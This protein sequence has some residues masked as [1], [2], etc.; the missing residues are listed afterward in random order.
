MN[1]MDLLE[2]Y[3]HWRCNNGSFD[4]LR[5]R[6]SEYTSLYGG[7]FESVVLE[8]QTARL[9]EDMRPRAVVAPIEWDDDLPF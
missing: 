9:S 1:A 5:C 4:D 6:V 8:I 7:S 2:Y 3:H